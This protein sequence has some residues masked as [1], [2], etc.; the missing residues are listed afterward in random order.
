MPRKKSAIIPY[1]FVNG[2]PQILLVTKSSGGKHDKRRWII[3]KGK[4]E[5]PLP[6]HISATKE[7]LEEAGVLGKLHPICVGEYKDSHKGYPIPVFLLEVE[8]E[9]S[10]KDW[11]EKD[12]RK[13]QWFDV[14]N[15]EQDLDSSLLDVIKEGVRCLRFDGAYF[16]RA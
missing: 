2:K 1:K 9:L 16:T 10:D 7:A 6:S 15:C 8:A 13:R 12:E 3:P 4:I 14:G 5:A 11:K